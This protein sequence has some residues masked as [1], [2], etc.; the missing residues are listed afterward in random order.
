MQ[1]M[2]DTCKEKVYRVSKTISN[3]L[4]VTMNPM[5]VYEYEIYDKNT[6]CSILKI[7]YTHWVGSIMMLNVADIIRDQ[8]ALLTIFTLSFNVPRYKNINYKTAP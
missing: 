6:Y 2:N 8:G 5:S 1:K 3:Y 4:W 7:L